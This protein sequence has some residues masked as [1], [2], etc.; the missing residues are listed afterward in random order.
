MFA[1]LRGLLRMPTSQER[2]TPL[3]PVKTSCAIRTTMLSRKSVR[4]V[5]E[6]RDATKCL[7]KSRGR[8]P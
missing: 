1:G 7:S 2:G 6:D 4:I 5:C 3:S 8:D